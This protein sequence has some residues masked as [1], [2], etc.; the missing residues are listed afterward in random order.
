MFPTD[1]PI[2]SNFSAS[3]PGTRESHSHSK[4]SGS[5]FGR[6]ISNFFSKS[7][8]SYRSSEEHS[9][10]NSI[11][12]IFKS[13]YDRSVKLVDYI[14]RHIHEMLPPYFTKAGIGS[15]AGFFVGA[16]TPIGPLWG[17]VGGLLIANGWQLC[18]ECNTDRDKP[19]SVR[20]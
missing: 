15:V 6:N 19:A 16:L 11:S 20:L 3:I 12:S 8:M 7:H 1:Q 17:T 14:S 10:W 9:V 5:S 13:L 18:V 2:G 4:K